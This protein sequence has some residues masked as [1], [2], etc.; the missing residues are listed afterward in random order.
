MRSS[1]DRK[2]PQRIVALSPSPHC[3]FRSDWEIAKQPQ[4]A[5]KHPGFSQSGN[6]GSNPRS[7]TTATQSIRRPRGGVSRSRAED[8]REPSPLAPERSKSWLNLMGIGQGRS[9]L[10]GL[11]GAKPLVWV[12]MPQTSTAFTGSMRSWDI[13]R[14]R[15]KFVHRAPGLAGLTFASFTRDRELGRRM[16]EGSK[17][18]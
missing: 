7:G 9:M 12:D 17:S 5:A 15:L 10:A 1:G 16:H 4:T 13:Y 2:Q 3:F 11:V 18:S 14:A 8:E 6:R